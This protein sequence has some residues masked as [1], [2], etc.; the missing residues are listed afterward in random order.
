[1]ISKSSYQHKYFNIAL[2][3]MNFVRSCEFHPNQ[4][5]K[6]LHKIQTSFNRDLQS[7]T[8][9]CYKQASLRLQGANQA[10]YCYQNIMLTQRK[11]D[12]LLLYYYHI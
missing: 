5:W 2:S 7:D 11:F 1:M 8:N 6:R 4:M 3:K 10:S 12:Q 9:L